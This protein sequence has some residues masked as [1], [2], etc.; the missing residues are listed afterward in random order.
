MHNIGGAQNWLLKSVSRSAVLGI[1][2]L[3][4]QK[5]L[6]H[7]RRLGADFKTAQ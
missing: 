7:P 5:W 3:Y 1:Q 4:E 6:Q 2:V